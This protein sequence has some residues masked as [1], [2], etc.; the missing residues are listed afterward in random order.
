[1]VYKLDTTLGQTREFDAQTLGLEI[2]NEIKA[3]YSPMGF[4]RCS[5]VACCIPKLKENMGMKKP[6]RATL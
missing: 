3:G 6:V 5:R 1:M 2:H 4:M